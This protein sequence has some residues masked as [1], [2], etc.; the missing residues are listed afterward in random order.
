MKEKLKQAAQQKP[1]RIQLQWIGLIV[2]LV[3]MAVL[4]GVMELNILTQSA[5]AGVQ[6]RVLEG[7]RQELERDITAN[8]TRLA[9]LTSASVM[10]E[11]ARD[12]GFVPATRNDIKYLY[13]DNYLEREPLSVAIPPAPKTDEQTI[14]KPAYTL[15]VWDW[16]FQGTFTLLDQEGK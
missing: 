12:L 13:M 11:R 5:D 9:L 10:Q 7:R 14:L 3:V 15:S 6:I 16:L 4:A 2:V 8:R 1:W